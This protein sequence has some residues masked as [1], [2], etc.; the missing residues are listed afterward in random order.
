VRVTVLGTGT[1]FGV[2]MIG[3][4]CPVCIST[5]PC[6]VRTRS[7]V[8]VQIHGELAFLVDTSIDLR[9]QSLERG[10]RRA[11]AVFFTH[12]H[13]DHVN[14][15]DELRSFNWL[16]GGPVTLF[17]R[18]DILDD[19]AM[20]FAHC[21]HPPQ[22]GAGVP[23]IQ[24]QPIEEGKP[25][26]FHG[27]GVTPIPVKHGI[28]D[29]LGWRFDRFAYITDASH[30]PDTSME[31][32]R[33]VSVLIVNALRRASHPTHMNLEQALAVV[34]RVRPRQAYFTHICHEMEHAETN[35]SLPPTAQLAYDGLVIEV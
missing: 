35:A 6:N 1:S 13:S 29:I 24:L 30:I 9:Q 2:P 20:R 22:E 21:F 17:S 3:C 26:D 12:T 16:Q 27:V 34:D 7:S 4:E 31:M 32:L 23:A 19:I 11:D 10:I 8:H 14:G 25:F 33:G 15:L 28:L 5:D 18:C